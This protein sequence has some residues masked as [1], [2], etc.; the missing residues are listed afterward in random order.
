MPETDDQGLIQCFG[1]KKTY[2]KPVVEAVRGVDLSLK[3][4]EIFGLLGRNGAGKTTL[5]RMICA[6]MSPTAGKILVEGLDTTKEPL[7]IKR[8]LGVM[9]QENNIDP[10]FT[11]EENLE[12]FS[13]Y[14]DVPRA[15]RAPRIKE[16]LQFV[17]LD[18][19]KDMNSDKISGGMKRKLILA[20]CLVNDP[21][22]LIL[23][24]PTTGLDPEARASIWEKIR[25]LK[26]RGR[27]ILLTTHYMEEAD[28]LCDRI[29]IMDAGK[30]LF[31]G[32]PTALKHIIPE[33]VIS[34]KLTT[35]DE[36]LLKDWKSL[37]EIAEIS[38]VGQ[39]I[40]IFTRDWRVILPHLV[41]TVDVQNLNI[42][43]PTLEDVF[44]KVNK[45]PAILQR[46]GKEN[47]HQGG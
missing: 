38:V 22:I 2:Q 26:A 11:V 25:E 16:L 17:Q 12:I 10:D 15:I 31:I 45:N 9:S 37:S 24:E 36:N 20:R 30:I 43:E 33:T 40:K 4:G 14:H 42:Q 46:N 5:I 13:M 23:D 28:R 44:L 1:V 34:L 41:K 8:R 39:E 19:A 27:T 32:T 7:R 6:Y 29:A 35:V 3:K 47:D 21:E 18:S